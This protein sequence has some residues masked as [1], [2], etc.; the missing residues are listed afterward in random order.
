MD[1]MLRQLKMILSSRKRINPISRRSLKAGKPGYLNISCIEELS[2]ICLKSH[3][4]ERMTVNLVKRKRSIKSCIPCGQ[5]Q[6]ISAF[7]SQNLWIIDE[8][9]AYHYYLASDLKVSQMKPLNNESDKRPDILI[10]DKPVAFVEG[11]YPFCS[12]VVIELKKPEKMDYSE[13]KNPIQQV[14]DY[15]ETLKSGKAVDE[16][17]AVIR[18]GKNTQFYCYILANLTPRM[19]KFSKSYSLKETPDNMGYFGY[20]SNFNAYIEVIDYK[21]LLEDS[22]KR[23]RV[24]FDKLGLPH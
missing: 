14:I 5:H 2:S 23:N 12:A 15:I 20:N 18:M 24:L 16:N 8:K 3:S 11:D 1:Q 22:K 10:F 9:L 21:K 19:V 13:D 6:M 7:E 17:N 4:K